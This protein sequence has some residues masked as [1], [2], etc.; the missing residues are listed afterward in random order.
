VSYTLTLN[1]FSVTTSEEL[2]GSRKVKLVSAVLAA[3]TYIANARSAT[4]E[5][6]ACLAR[7]DLVADDLPPRFLLHFRTLFRLGADAAELLRMLKRVAAALQVLDNEMSTPKLRFIEYGTDMVTSIFSAAAS[8]VSKPIYQPTDFGLTRGFSVAR[9]SNYMGTASVDGCVNT[10]RGTG[11]PNEIQIKLTTLD[12]NL[13][14]VTDTVIHEAT[15]KF[16]GTEDEGMNTITFNWMKDD[17]LA[18]YIRDW[19]GV[20]LPMHRP[21][22]LEKSPEEAMANAYILTAYIMYLPEGDITARAELNRR[23]RLDRLRD[24]TDLGQVLRAGLAARRPPG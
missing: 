1:N 18:L 17:G 20:M 11:N 21:A 8:L 14:D 19:P 23:I 3:R 15:H 6:L 10:N 22:F 4:F 12:M 24:G 2:S 5:A 13:E 9:L 7:P 16:L